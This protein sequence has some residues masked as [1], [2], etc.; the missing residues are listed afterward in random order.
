MPKVGLICFNTVHV[1]V[2][3]KSFIKLTFFVFVF[4]LIL[5]TP[6]GRETRQDYIIVTNTDLGS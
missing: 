4:R 6:S 2:R 1:K 3:M 5:I